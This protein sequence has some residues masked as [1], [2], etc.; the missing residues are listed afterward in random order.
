[1]RRAS[2]SILLTYTFVLLGIVGFLLILIVVFGSIPTHYAVER[3]A[4]F[5]SMP[6]NDSELEAWLN[7]Q[8]R[9]FHASCERQGNSVL[10]IAF[11]W[12]DTLNRGLLGMSQFPDL[13]AA[14]ERLGY[15]GQKGPFRGSPLDGD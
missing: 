3:W 11:I 13:E 10:R 1:M 6:P 8:P 7:A 4:A 5:A 2:K 14:C 15:K 12:E 9:V